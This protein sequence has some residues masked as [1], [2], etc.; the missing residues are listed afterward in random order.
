MKDHDDKLRHFDLYLS[1][2]LSL[3]LS[4]CTCFHFP[5]PTCFQ[6]SVLLPVIS[7]LRLF[8]ALCTLVLQNAWNSP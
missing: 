6:L 4:L 7:G 2:S 5:F 1:L 3:S 8:E